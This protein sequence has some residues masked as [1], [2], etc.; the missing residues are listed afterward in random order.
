MKPHVYR[1]CQ[2]SECPEYNKEVELIEEER[3]WFYIN[4]FCSSCHHEGKI[5]LLHKT[6]E[7]E[8]RE[9]FY[10][11]VGGMAKEFHLLRKLVDKGVADPEDQTRYDEILEQIKDLECTGCGQEFIN[12]EH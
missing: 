12:H 10:A 6:I 3:K 5:R 2:D 1:T 7:A 11:K 9:A 8:S 4:P